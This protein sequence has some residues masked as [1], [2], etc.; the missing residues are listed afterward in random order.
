MCLKLCHSYVGSDEKVVIILGYCAWIPSSILTAGLFLK[1]KTKY[2]SSGTGWMLKIS[3]KRK[4]ITI[5][6]NRKDEERRRMRFTKR[7]K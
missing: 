2:I 3:G 5:C 7:L 1:Y 4:K 6:N